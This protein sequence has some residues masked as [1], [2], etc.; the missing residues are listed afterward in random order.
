MQCL[1]YVFC[2]MIRRPPRSTRTDTLFPYTTLFRSLHD[3]AGI[4]DDRVDI[5]LRRGHIDFAE[6]IFVLALGVVDPLEHLLHLV[7]RYVGRRL[8]VARQQAIPSEFAADLLL[9]R[10]RRRSLR[11]QIFA[12]LLGRLL[13]ERSEERRVRKE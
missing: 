13:D 11:C 6:V 3:L 2:F 1:Y 12:E 5:V 8:D 9:D 7:G 10:Y 4:F